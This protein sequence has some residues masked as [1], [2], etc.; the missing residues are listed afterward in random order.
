MTGGQQER[1]ERMHMGSEGKEPSEGLLDY[2]ALTSLWNFTIDAC[3]PSF[4]KGRKYLGL[5]SQGLK[6]GLIQQGFR[7]NE[8]G[9]GI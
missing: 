4:S 3:E 7:W 1:K 9:A 2:Q 6:R 5:V 8:H